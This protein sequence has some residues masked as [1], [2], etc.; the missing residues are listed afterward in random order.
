MVSCRRRLAQTPPLAL[1]NRDLAC[2]IHVRHVNLVIPAPAVRASRRRQPCFR[3][4]SLV[5]VI[6][7]GQ[8]RME[9]GRMPVLLSR[10]LP[11]GTPLEQE[12]KR[13]Q[14]D[15]GEQSR[16]DQPANNHDGERALGFCA[17]SV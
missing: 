14:D 3:C 15:Q 10:N 17:N 5:Q 12:V 9:T 7:W 4:T 11:A 2:L 8:K 16:R 1:A 13:R 6:H